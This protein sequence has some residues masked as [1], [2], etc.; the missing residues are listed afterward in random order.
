MRNALGV[1]VAAVGGWAAWF[2]WSLLPVRL[3]GD[4]WSLVHLAVAG[5]VLLVSVGVAA[6]ISGTARAGVLDAI[7]ALVAFSVA[8]VVGFGDDETGLFVVGLVLV[9]VLAGWAVV[10]VGYLVGRRGRPGMPRP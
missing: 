6:A 5:A 9:L 1:L 8:W 10:L 7:V 4:D 2:A 3:I